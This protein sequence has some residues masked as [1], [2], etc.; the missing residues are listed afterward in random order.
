MISQSGE[1][2]HGLVGKGQRGNAPA[3]TNKHAHISQ[4]ADVRL[5]FPLPPG[6]RLDHY[7]IR[8]VIGSGGF[9]ITYRAEHTVLGKN[10]AIKEYFPQAFSYREGKTVRPTTS[11]GPTYHWGLERFTTEARALARFKHPAIVDI[12]SIFEANGTAYIVLGYERGGPM[13][14]W[15]RRI[16]RL[17]TQEDL[18]RIVDPLLSALDEIHQDGLMHRDIAP[19]NILIRENGAPVLID[20]GSAR[21][22]VRNASHAMSAIVK[23]GYSP[24]EQYSS[25]SDLQGAWTDIYALAATLYRAMTG[26]TPPDATE[27][28][29]HDKILSVGRVSKGFYRPG[30]IE[31]VD[32]GL[33]IRPEGRPQ[34]IAQW[35]PM[36]FRSTGG[37]V[38]PPPGSAAQSTPGPIS[39]PPGGSHPASRPSSNPIGAANSHPRESVRYTASGRP[40][41]SWLDEKEA[42]GDSEETASTPANQG[43]Q[44]VFHSVLGLLGGAVAGALGS[45]VLASTFSSSCFADS[46]IMAYLIP[47]TL[48]GAVG[49][50]AIAYKV[51]KMNAEAAVDPG[52]AGRF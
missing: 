39:A 6:T 49:G 17:P 7:V 18:D 1:P 23:H 46:C 8:D 45:I 42:A 24:P 44:V 2:V 36:L 21:E 37:Y 9:G 35:R 48:L 15:L 31:G 13:S 20:F 32:W 30:F 26:E 29:M 27:R 16:G 47:C 38:A 19:D 5:R 52:N 25:R 3:M 14:D 41:L 51:A 22:S 50:A 10:Y 33:Q 43:A 11:S 4:P 34:T 40:D 12:A 28:I